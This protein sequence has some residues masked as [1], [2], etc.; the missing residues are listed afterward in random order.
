MERKNT[1]KKKYKEI[2]ELLELQHPNARPE[3]NFKNRYELIVAVILSAQCTDARVNKVTDV[4]FRRAPNAHTLAGM[5]LEEIEE[6]VRSCGIRRKAGYIRDTAGMIVR[7][8]GGE[9]P[10]DY[11][12]LV[13]FPGVSRKTANVVLSVG[14]GIP[15]IAVDTH[16]FR[17]SNR[18]GIASGKNVEKVEEDLREH[19]DP[20][21][22]N[23][24]HHLLIFHGRY[25]CKA[26]KPECGRC[27]L[28]EKCAAYA[29]GEFGSA[30]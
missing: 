7:D 18:M 19:F 4:L 12:E 23:R 11:H 3:L 1:V 8:Y 17:V 10:G 30:G 2:Y 24:L 22:W 16:V 29:R 21:C 20:G 14:F 26:R 25:V 28:T 6:I 5:P 15:A 13:K 27:M 9:V